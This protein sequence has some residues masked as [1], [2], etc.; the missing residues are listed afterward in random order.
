VDRDNDTLQF[1]ETSL[2]LYTL[3]RQ[4]ANVQPGGWRSPEDFYY[5]LWINDQHALS[6][7]KPTLNSVPSTFPDLT[8][9]CES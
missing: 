1:N 9:N 2:P 4:T 3:Q 6:L 7:L 8:R 5:S